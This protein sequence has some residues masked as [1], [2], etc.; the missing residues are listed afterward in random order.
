MIKTFSFEKYWDLD[1]YKDI[2][3]CVSKANYYHNNDFKYKF[4]R[5]YRVRRNCGWQNSF[6][7]LF[8][9]AMNNT[10]RFAE[11]LDEMY[12]KTGRFEA[13]YVSKMLATVDCNMPIYDKNVLNFLG[14]SVPEKKTVE[15]LTTIY[16][17]I[18][19]KNSDYADSK[20]GKEYIEWFDH[21]LSDYKWISSTKK[22]DFLFWT[23]GSESNIDF[24]VQ[25][26]LNNYVEGFIK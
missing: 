12:K 9:R 8:S 18:I 22:V 20:K 6:Y 5:F 14:I 15:N 3:Q 13:S 7:D 25:E 2:M 26:K 21:D 10:D 24:L 4:N 11:L 19:E 16:K 23:M 17:Q 1:T